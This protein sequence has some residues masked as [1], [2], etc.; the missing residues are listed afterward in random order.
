MGVNFIVLLILIY[1][2]L[3][4]RYLRRKNTHAYAIRII[5]LLAYLLAESKDYPLHEPE[6]VFKRA[7]YPKG[8]VNLWLKLVYSKP[9]LVAEEQD[10][11]AIDQA[12]AHNKDVAMNYRLRKRKLKYL[13]FR[14]FD[15]VKFIP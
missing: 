14:Y 4:F 8:E 12:L 5:Y 11:K 1:L 3:P 9:E 10:M 7:D 6:Y 2:R 13:K 15:I